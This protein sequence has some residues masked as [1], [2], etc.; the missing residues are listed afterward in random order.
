MKHREES[1]EQKQEMRG[2][3]YQDLLSTV[4]LLLNLLAKVSLRQ[5]KVLSHLPTVLE[6]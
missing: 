6:Q 5:T 3:P 4:I 2:G 1:W